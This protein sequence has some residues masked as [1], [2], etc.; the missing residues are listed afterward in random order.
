MWQ[1]LIFLLLV[2]FASCSKSERAVSIDYSWVERKEL[3]SFFTELLLEEGGVYTLLGDKPMTSLLIFSGNLSDISI[4]NLSESSLK[5]L[6]FIEYQTA[7]N[8]K[9]GKMHID[10]LALKKFRFVELEC[11]LDPSYS[12]VLFL[13]VEKT[14]EVI[15]NHWNAFLQQGQIPFESKESFQDIDDLPLAIWRTILTDHYLS[16]LLYG[17]GEENIAY[18]LKE[19]DE[20]VFSECFEGNI[21][22]ENFP[23]P[24]FASTEGDQR[25]KEYK[26]QREK[27]KKLFRGKDFLDVT[28]KKLTS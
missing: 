19:Y 7:S 23:I 3:E 25:S 12:Y 14:M 15:K 8:W 28:L 2:F 1:V 5:K 24:I 6:Q 20:K 13:N 11:P 9:L 18:F 4:E 26:R 21:S 16:G 17:Y 27:I 10:K 22:C